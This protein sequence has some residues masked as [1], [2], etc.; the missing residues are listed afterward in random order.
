V[1]SCLGA[2][3]LPIAQSR[4]AFSEN[5]SVIIVGVTARALIGLRAAPIFSCHA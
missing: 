4:L 5:R 1:S 2:R 3:G